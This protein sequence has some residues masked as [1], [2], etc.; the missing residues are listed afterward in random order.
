MSQNCLE[1]VTPFVDQVRDNPLVQ[2]IGGVG[3]FV[4]ETPGVEIIPDE[5]RIVAA[6]DTDYDQLGQFRNEDRG[7]TKRDLDVLVTSTNP[8]KIEEVK[9]AAEQTIGDQLAI[10]VF[11]LRRASKLP[12]FNNHP[13]WAMASNWLGDRYIG[14]DPSGEIF[15]D[16]ALFPF[17]A[18][19]HPETLET[20]QLQTGRDEDQTI[21]VPHPGTTILN[22]FG[23]SISG[24][25][26]KDEQKI[27]RV[28]QNIVKAA[29]WIK[30]WLTS[31]PGSSQFEM[32]RAIHS[33]RADD[34]KQPLPIAPGFDLTAI[35][36]NK[37]VRHEALM[38]GNPK[39]IELLLDVCR[40]K[41]QALHWFEAK[42]AVVSVYQRYAERYMGY[43]T[44]AK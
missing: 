27:A 7:G 24:I 1:I 23:R 4:Y 25:R 37:L 5:R 16:R 20:W 31:G 42:N 41:S 30:D 28:G 12:K 35:P 21:P 29:P 33:L 6:P 39:D 15:V 10:S 9:S 38:Y 18:R 26:P 34:N 44:G 13:G 3:T 19:M 43:F 32:A 17:A 8:Q 14:R 2:M 22:Y 36:E 11:G 40:A